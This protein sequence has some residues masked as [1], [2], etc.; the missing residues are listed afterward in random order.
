[1]N[2]KGFIIDCI[3]GY[4]EEIN[5]SNGYFAFG[6][7]SWV[8]NIYWNEFW[9]I[10]DSIRYRNYLEYCIDNDTYLHYNSLIIFLYTLNIYDLKKI[11]KDIEEEYR[12]CDT[13]IVNELYKYDYLITDLYQD[14]YNDSLLYFNL[15]PHEL[16]GLITMEVNNDISRI[17]DITTLFNYN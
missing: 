12:L 5:I 17:I 7:D 2:D 6:N 15:L 4:N 9:K 10:Y 3:C 13:T 16:F 11:K 1:M 14:L 8:Y